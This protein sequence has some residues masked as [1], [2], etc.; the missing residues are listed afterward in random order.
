MEDT[1]FVN[2][3]GLDTASPVPYSTAA[4]MARVTLYA[5]QKPTFAFYTSQSQRRV[6]YLK[7]GTQKQV[8]MLKNTNELV[9][10]NGIDGVKTGTTARAG[11]CLILTASKK[12][13]VVKISEDN[14]AVYPRRLVAVLLAAP[15]RFGQGLGLLDQGWSRHE[16]WTAAGRP[17]HDPSEF[18]DPVAE[19]P[20]NP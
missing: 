19:A 18:L 17:V 14:H 4:D 16:Q 15:D 6:S 9:G 2:P 11:Q 1:K 13:I 7:G 20:R 8:F 12:P 3:H 10:R 5:L